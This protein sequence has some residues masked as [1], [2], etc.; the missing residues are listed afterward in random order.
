M[1]IGEIGGFRSVE[2]APTV[3]VGKKFDLSTVDVGRCGGGTKDGIDPWSIVGIGREIVGDGDVLSSL[4]DLACHPLLPQE[5]G[6]SLF[7]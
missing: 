3:V 5:I 6:Q 4:I 2:G 1:H 7:A